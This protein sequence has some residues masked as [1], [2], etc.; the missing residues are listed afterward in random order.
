MKNEFLNV[1]YLTFGFS[2]NQPLNLGDIPCS[3]TYL[4]FVDSFNQPLS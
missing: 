3:V 2:F 4:T 1:K